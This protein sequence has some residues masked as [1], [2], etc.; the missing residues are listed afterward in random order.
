MSIENVYPIQLTRVKATI[1]KCNNRLIL[2]DTGRSNDDAETILNYARTNLRM[3]L[4]NYGEVCIVTHHHRDHIGGLNKI[5]SRCN[6]KIASYE[7]A[8]IESIINF[9]IYSSSE[10]EKLCL[11]AEEYNSFTSLGIP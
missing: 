3:P 10:I 6:L 4:E 8:D 9:K 7:A 11:F 1:P 5:K 2:V